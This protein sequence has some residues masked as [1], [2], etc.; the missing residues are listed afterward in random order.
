MV[1]AQVQYPYPT[2]AVSVIFRAFDT[3]FDFNIQT[4]DYRLHDGL[5]D[6]T[7]GIELCRNP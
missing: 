3:F 1:V 6:E 4:T 7:E 5:C 2:A